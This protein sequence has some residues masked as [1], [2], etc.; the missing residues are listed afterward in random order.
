M[1]TITLI[2]GLTATAL[3]QQPSVTTWGGLRFGMTVAQAKTTLAGQI[4]SEERPPKNPTAYRLVLKPVILEPIVAYGVPNI[5]FERDRL[6][7]VLLDYSVPTAEERQMAEENR[8]KIPTCG[9]GDGLQTTYSHKERYSPMML[10]FN[11]IAE[12]MNGVFQEKY[13]KPIN[14]TGIWPS[15]DAASKHYIHVGYLGTHPD[16]PASAIADVLPEWDKQYKYQRAWKSGG[17]MIRISLSIVCDMLFLDV[18]YE[19][20]N[21][22]NNY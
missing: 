19:P 18:E 14:E 17:Q 12:A 15:E 6:I 11:A 4:A 5:I 9:S 21:Q 3:A 7:R 13:G 2:L 16:L 20:E 1:K 8:S 10:N 22:I